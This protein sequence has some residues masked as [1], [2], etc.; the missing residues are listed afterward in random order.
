MLNT[1]ETQNKMRR[2]GRPLDLRRC[3]ARRH[4]KV[5]CEQLVPPRGRAC[6]VWADG[7]KQ[8]LVKGKQTGLDGPAIERPD[9]SKEWWVDNKRHRQDGP[10]IDSADGRKEWW[11][12]NKR[13]RL[14][15]PAVEHA[16]GGEEWWVDNKRH[17]EDGPA[18]ERANGSK[19]WWVD[20][21]E[22]TEEEFPEAVLAYRKRF[23]RGVK[24]CRP[25]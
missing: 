5:G 19:E 11:V 2:H 13:H 17:R 4:Q 20:H 1:H 18:V 14:D 9:G 10:A 16:Y 24:P 21:E 25:A 12:E 8:W 23:G 3:H 15:G 22:F 7:T 6:I